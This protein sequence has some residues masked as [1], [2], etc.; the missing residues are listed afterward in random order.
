ML[1]DEG[2]MP[3][4]CSAARAIGYRQALAQLHRWRDNPETI[5]AN[6]VVC[7]ANSVPML[8]LSAPIPPSVSSPP[9]V[10]VLLV[11]EE[12]GRTQVE[13]VIAVQTA[14]RQYCHRQLTW[15][16]GL[17]LFSWVDADQGQEAV[18]EQILAELQS[19]T[20]TG[21]QSCFTGFWLPCM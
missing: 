14:S 1:L 2:V 8:S 17:P 19:A 10:D 18:V 16:R 13:L 11:T 4:S 15:A 9:L 7:M 6:S 3:D 20:H 12:H 21:D 5:T